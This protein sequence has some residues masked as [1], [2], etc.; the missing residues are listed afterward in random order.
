MLIWLFLLGITFS[1]I[2]PAINFYLS[3]RNV[4]YIYYILY[5]LFSVVFILFTFLKYNHIAIF[6]TL[7]LTGLFPYERVFN[8]IAPLFYYLFLWHYVLKSESYS[9]YRRILKY[10]INT[11]LILLPILTYLEIHYSNSF[12]QKT[13]TTIGGLLV[14]LMVGYL[15][16]L[17]IKDRNNVF[18]IIGYGLLLFMI[19]VTSSLFLINL[20][21]ST[22]FAQNPHSMYLIGM[23]AEL[24]F[25]N[26]ALNLSNLSYRQQ[27]VLKMNN[28]ESVALRSQ[29]NP[30]FVHNSLNAIQ[31]FIQR[32]EVELSENYLVKFSKLIRLFFEY[33]RQQ[34]ISIS[35]EIE[36]LTN[37][38]EIEKLRF[39]EKLKY[40]ITVCENIDP[41]NQVISSMILQPI[42]ENAVNHGL[43][44]KKGKGLVSVNFKKINETEFEVIVK[45]NGIGI[46]KAKKIY[47]HS[48]KNYQ[49]NSSEVLQERIEL[50]NQSK[51]RNIT[52]KI[53]DLSDS[54]NETGT[55]VT[56]TFKQPKK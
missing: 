27:L 19:L 8:S 41:D 39:E 48:P 36:L 31:Y 42:V 28:I 38:L 29:M 45:D 37:Y 14:L 3:E 54:S 20:D 26:Y 30:H 21:N 49:S 15:S 33:S 6:P 5:I 25:L 51:D 22:M 46:H 1:F 17:L 35:D 7:N 18:R 16:V 23:I 2:I 32:N 12:L 55:L 9:K 24:S 53:E 40:K 44:H 52:Y 43:F 10:L 4:S 56:L 34:T 50:L 47:K 13:A 11:T